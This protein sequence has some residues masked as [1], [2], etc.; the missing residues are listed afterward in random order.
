MTLQKLLSDP[1]FQTVVVPLFT[2]LIPVV[3]G[4]VVG[5]VAA[6][7]KKAPWGRWL[8][9]VVETAVLGFIGRVFPE[10]MAAFNSDDPT[11]KVIGLL[12]GVVLVGLLCMMVADVVQLVRK[13]STLRTAEMDEARWQDNR[14]TLMDKVRV[15]WIDGVLKNSLYEQARI[16]VGLEEWP[17]MVG[18]EWQRA[19]EEKQVLPPGT[20]LLIWGVAERCW[21]WGSRV[22]GKQHCC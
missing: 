8:K 14:Q 9:L 4:W 16:S 17:E 10:A 7:Q 22:P 19:R 3:L 11:A 2:V 13:P 1:N 12:Y 20:R 21:C 15:K 18:M 5:Q 6:A